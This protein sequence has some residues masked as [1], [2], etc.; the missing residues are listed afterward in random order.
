MEPI[1][2]VLIAN[3]GEIALRIL[4]TCKE[5]GLRTIAVYSDADRDGPVARQADLA[6]RLGPAPAGESYLDAERLLAAAQGNGADAIHPG[7]GFLAENADFSEACAAQGITF[8]GPSPQVIRAMG[9]KA[10]AKRLMRK[11]G[12]PVIPGSE[13]GRQ[14][15]KTLRR[16][17]EQVGFP[18]LVKAVAGGGG[19]GIRLVTR[20][21]E[22]ADALASARREAAAG[23]GDG[24]LMLE[25]FLE[26]PHHV[27][28]QIMADAHGSVLH[29]FEREC[30][31]QR[32][33][34]KIVEE[35]PSP[36]LHPEKREAMSAAALTAA[37]AIGYLGAGTVEFM[38]DDAGDF[39]FLE[40]NTRLQVEHPITEMTLGVDMVRMQIEVAQGLPLTVL[41]SQLRPAGHAVECRLNAERP[42]RRFLPST[43]N[44]L[45]FAF[46]SGPGLRVD[47]G[48]EEGAE[49]G[50]HYDNLLAKLV[51][52]GPS[53]PEALRKMSRMLAESAV[54]GVDTNLA[55]LQAVLARPEFRAGAYNTRF[56]EELEAELVNDA[57]PPELLREILLAAAAVDAL[58]LTGRAG[59][60]AGNAAQRNGNPSPAQGTAASPWEAGVPW[61]SAGEGGGAAFRR[62]YGLNG[63]RHEARVQLLPHNG[64]GLS[65]RVECQGLEQRVLCIPAGAGRCILDLEEARLP[66]NWGAQGEERWLSLRGAHVH[67]TS[68]NP[69]HGE[70]AGNTGPEGRRKLTAPLPGTVIKIA[71]KKGQR[72]AANDLLAIVE[73][74]KMEHQITAPFGGTVGAVHFREGDRVNKDDLLLDLEPESE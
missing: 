55:F 19:R 65:L 10:Q 37:R 6:V 48:Y 59:P 3:R 27:E 46:P 25:K 71:V 7:Y 56:V 49:V 40:M 62:E 21:S 28:F 31:I 1:E 15:G 51:A 32:R 39:Y 5:M 35:T 58:L 61:A 44:L 22:L 70:A 8:I 20:Q 18:L 4:R 60:G 26:R 13:P 36:A 12:V 30:S 29:L 54:C 68:H 63:E 57:P 50:A 66:L 9:D 73:A 43:G 64:E 47:T 52:W 69:H 23:F 42:A 38:L 11:A 14:D 72:V 16:A 67:L 53:R 45:R 74:V 34:Q 24:R 33:H 2:S 17:A 41:Q